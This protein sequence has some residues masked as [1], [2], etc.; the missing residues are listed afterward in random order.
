MNRFQTTSRAARAGLILLVAMSIVAAACGSS[1]KTTKAAATSPT[2]AA[3][4]KIVYHNVLKSDRG[5][6]QGGGQPRLRHRG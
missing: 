4:T 2:T 6:A 5:D 3:N 1:A